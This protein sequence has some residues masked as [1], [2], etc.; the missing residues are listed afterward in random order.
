MRPQEPFD[1]Q[2]LQA[3]MENLPMSK[4]APEE[5]KEKL[6]DIAASPAPKYR[7]TRRP[8]LAFAMGGATIVA[9]IAL[10][11]SLPATAKSWDGIKK[12]VQA[13]T[14]MEM[15]VK[16]LESKE[17]N[18]HIGFAPGTI[19]V[20]PEDG[21]IVYVANGTVQIYDKAENTVREFPLPSNEMIPDIAGTVLSEM[22][23]TKML[24]NYEKEYGRQNIK[25]GAP[26][27]WQGR[28]VYDAT[29]RDTK[30]G[31][32]A[33]LVIDEATD[34]PIFIEAFEL[35]NGK[36][37]KTTEITARYNDAVDPNAIKPKFPEGAKFEKFDIQKMI[38][39][40]GGGK[41]TP[42]PF[43]GD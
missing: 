28:R 18:V 25:L 23:M 31:G 16:D 41:G 15:V 3:L 8:F 12:A 21:E 26:R 1:E 5:L 27:M 38:E 11:T 19:L 37:V 7:R 34:L 2:A 13:V 35:R 43:F 4:F 42:P 20:Q 40:S 6:V 30:D 24:A 9:A 39:Q 29:L 33:N 32:H 14:R 10:M 36:E 17:D 22:S